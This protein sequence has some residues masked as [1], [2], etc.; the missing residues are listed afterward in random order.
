MYKLSPAIPIT[1][2]S[3]LLEI[4]RYLESHIHKMFKVIILKLSLYSF[5]VSLLVFCVEDKVCVRCR[6][7]DKRI[8]AGHK[9]TDITSVQV[10]LI[11]NF[12]PVCTDMQQNGKNLLCVRNKKI[13]HDLKIYFLNMELFEIKILICFEKI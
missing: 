7:T 12:S 1:I 5:P 11:N 2:F 3:F 13:Q 9:W 6:K 4:T 8:L 10:K